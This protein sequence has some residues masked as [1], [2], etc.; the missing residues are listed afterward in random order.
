M[1]G[2][3]LPK[4][5]HVR[6]EIYFSLKD[7]AEFNQKLADKGEAT[8]ANPRNSASGALRQIDSTITAQR[9]LNIFCYTVFAINGIV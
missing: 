7:F 3:N 1:K 9:P 5:L 2:K 4:E 8:Y 6:G